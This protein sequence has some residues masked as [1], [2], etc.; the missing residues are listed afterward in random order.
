MET[1][2]DRQL[3]RQYYQRLSPSGTF[4]LY[5]RRTGGIASLSCTTMMPQ[6]YIPNGSKDILLAQNKATG[7]VP[8]GAPWQPGC[9]GGVAWGAAMNI[10][11]WEFYL[12][13]ADKDLLAAN[14]TGMKE[15]LRYMQTWVD[16]DGI[17]LSQI[18]ATETSANGTTWEN[19]ARQTDSPKD[20][21]HTFYLLAL[22]RS[23]GKSGISTGREKGCK[24]FLRSGRENTAGFPQTFL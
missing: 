15:Q 4:C 19:G 22:C 21:V 1:K 11:P 9:G 2:P 17:M 5:R 10:M 7:Y 18:K 24:P 20:L 3:T 16:S 14:Y 13:Y 12:H 23:Y 8:N 6:L